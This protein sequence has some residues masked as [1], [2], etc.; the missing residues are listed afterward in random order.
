M[1]VVRQL[2]KTRPTKF[3]ASINCQHAKLFETRVVMPRPIV[4]TRLFQSQAKRNIMIRPM[5]RNFSSSN[6][7]EFDD[8]PLRLKRAH[9]REELF[10]KIIGTLLGTIFCMVIFFVTLWCPPIGMA[11][12][13]FIFLS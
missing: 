5:T 4:Q 13:L 3:T 12:V 8:R 7:N 6:R 10:F 9:E 1:F 2:L 11:I